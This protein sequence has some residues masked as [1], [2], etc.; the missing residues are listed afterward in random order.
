MLFWL[1]WACNSEK[2]MTRDEMLT[3]IEQYRSA[4]DA[5][6]LTAT[7][8]EATADC[9]DIEVNYLREMARCYYFYDLP[10]LCPDGEAE[11]YGEMEAE[12]SRIENLSTECA[13]TYFGF[14]ADDAP[15]ERDCVRAQDGATLM[16]AANSRDQIQS[17]VP[18]Q[19][20]VLSTFQTDGGLAYL[21]TTPDGLCHIVY[22][23]ITDADSALQYAQT[24]TP[25]DC[26]G[27]NGQSLG[28]CDTSTL[29]IYTRLNDQGLY[30]AALELNPTT[31]PAG[32]YI[33]GYNL[34]GALASLLAAELV[35]ADSSTYSTEYLSVVTLGEPQ[36]FDAATAADYDTRITKTRWV[37]W[38]DPVTQNGMGGHFGV[39][40][41]L[42]YPFGKEHPDYATAFTEVDHSFVP[43]G[44]DLNQ[45]SLA[46]KYAV[47]LSVCQD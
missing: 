41:E 23:G 47:K 45:H 39:P 11:C 35:T 14:Y 28:S 5:R 32:L 2:E 6:H 8:S 16:L 19:Y 44:E 43:W 10:T 1:L 18:S 46:D 40:V 42:F 9:S 15:V 4:W 20:Q 24:T 36:V 27:A 31:C 38:A 22:K 13:D 3:E 12:C 29:D 33:Y 37:T 26:L 7:L 21:A 34:G 17:L 25:T 30:T